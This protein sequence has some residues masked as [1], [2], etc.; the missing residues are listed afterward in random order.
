MQTMRQNIRYVCLSDTHFGD[1]GSLLTC[2]KPASSDPDPRRPSPVLIELVKCLRYLVSHNTTPEKPI[3]V[4]NGDILELAL[5]SD[6]IALMSFERFLELTLKPEDKRLFSE[7]V[8]IPGNHDH[9]VWESARETQYVEHITTR[10]PANEALPPPWH[11]TRLSA[12]GSEPV[13]P[14]LLDRLMRSRLQIEGVPIS[15][16]YPNFGVFSKDRRKSVIFSHGH[17]AEPLY[18]VMSRLKTYLFRNTMMPRDVWELE[19]ENFAWIDFFWSV[20]G[21]QGDAG[22]GVELVYKSLQDEE[23]VRKIADRLAEGLA[24]TN[25]KGGIKLLHMREWRTEK[26]VRLV[27]RILLAQAS[28]LERGQAEFNSPGEPLS[29]MVHNGLDAYMSGPLRGQI[30]LEQ[31]GIMPTDLTFVFGHTHKPFQKDMHFDGYPEWVDVYNTG[32]WVVETKE[33]SP[34]HGGAMVLVNDDCDAVSLQMF[35]DWGDDKANVVDVVEVQQSKPEHAEKAPHAFCRRIQELVR[36]REE[37]W[38]SFS[39]SA[40]EAISRRRN[41]LKAMI[42]SAGSDEHQGL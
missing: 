16:R 41:N 10:V 18:T 27:L 30:L 33:P 24:R 17:L 36:P 35:R 20:M 40:A 8:Y 13:V 9:H 19:G 7:I 11:T 15:V 4:L 34:V 26:L 37:P 1:D 12:Q 21:R 29:E 28:K 22:K 5:S 14:Y 3:L 42:K 32:G 31:D 2:L 6:P 39:A 38:R 25:N 23:Q